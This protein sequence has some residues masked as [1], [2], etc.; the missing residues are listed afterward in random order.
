MRSVSRLARVPFS[1]E[2]MFNLVCDVE[3]YPEFLPWCTATEL[4]SRS[5]SEVL[6]TLAIG[7]RSLNIEF[8]TRNMFC[9]SE[10]MTMH[11]V[12]GPFSSLEGRWTFNSL[13]DDGCEVALRMDFDFSS[14]VKDMLFGMAFETICNELIDAFVKRAHD[15]YGPQAHET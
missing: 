1:A 2:A 14:S 12:E 6:A 13:G 11:L 8:T 5:E 9:A 10:W 3:S 7:Y 4:Q 15:L